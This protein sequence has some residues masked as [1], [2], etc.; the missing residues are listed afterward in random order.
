[1]GMAQE[2]HTYADLLQKI[3]SDLRMQH[4]EWIEPNGEP[5]NMDE[6]K[7]DAY[8]FGAIP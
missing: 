3:H 8:Q 4:P 2:I 6:P 5:L 1:M 7:F